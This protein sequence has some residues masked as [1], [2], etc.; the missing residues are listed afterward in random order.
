MKAL[1]NIFKALG[2]LNPGK[3]TGDITRSLEIY[4]NLGKL[5]W[6]LPAYPMKK[7][8]GSHEYNQVKRSN[9]YLWY[10]EKT[11]IDLAKND[12][13][14]AWKIYQKALNNSNALQAYIITKTEKGWYHNQNLIGFLKW[15][16]KGIERIRLMRHKIDFKRTYIPKKNGKMRP[17]GVPSRDSRY[18]LTGVTLFL[19]K[20]LSPRIGNYQ[21]G[22]REQKSCATALL[23]LYDEIKAGKEVYEFDLKSFFNTVSYKEVCQSL[24]QLVPGLGNWIVNC[25]EFSFPEMPKEHYPE[26]E[27]LN[28]GKSR[29]NFPM[30]LKRGFSQGANWSPIL[31]T[32]ALELAGFGKIPG[33]I[34][35]ADDG[36]IC[37]DQRDPIN[38]SDH[39]RLGVKIAED[40]ANGWTVN[41]IKFLG[42][43][44]NK[45]TNMITDTHGKTISMNAD[46]QS[47]VNFLAQVRYED[48]HP[49]N[50]QKQN[51][52][53]WW[54]HPKFNSL[55]GEKWQEWLNPSIRITASKLTFPTEGKVMLEKHCLR[56]DFTTRGERIVY[57]Q[58]RS[59]TFATAWLLDILETNINRK[60]IQVLTEHYIGNEHAWD[61]S[62]SWYA[63]NGT[64]ICTRQEQYL[65]PIFEWFMK[66]SYRNIEVTEYMNVTKP[67]YWEVNGKSPG[68]EHQAKILK[69]NRRKVMIRRAAVG[70]G[71]FL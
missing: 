8:H 38:L 64:V 39:L 14:K 60:K 66:W 7:G 27:M 16:N 21:H 37:R 62:W 71:V 5:S 58:A 46:R 31:A 51:N 52:K 61:P 2:F 15:V 45:W 20:L 10:L 26:M 9:R 11:I 19:S 35:Y 54:W 59:S 30:W 57:D 4:Q 23:S 65:D 48:R 18:M 43:T 28:I 36:V 44:F 22:F 6:R 70:P 63:T 67:S 25:T 32:Y 53:N 12:P 33:L 13:K 1:W 47:I 56:A 69:H 55:L 49:T 42:C 40:K 29:D 41:Q 3:E 17:L 24:E 68:Y 34:M 50:Y